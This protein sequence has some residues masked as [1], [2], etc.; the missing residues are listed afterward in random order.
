MVLTQEVLS[1]FSNTLDIEWKQPVH[2]LDFSSCCLLCCFSLPHFLKCCLTET[3]ALKQL[4]MSSF[5]STP[6]IPWA[7][8]SC[9]SSPTAN[10]CYN[11]VPNF[12][13]LHLSKPAWLQLHTLS[14]LVAQ[15]STHPL[16]VL[17]FLQMKGSPCTHWWHHLC[18]T[19]AHIW[20]S[21]S[22]TF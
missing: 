11:M 13:L 3:N 16:C 9:K 8:S 18:E 10:Y 4:L 20:L 1:K 6:L 14:H 5:P 19:H 12:V 22:F 7:H 21:H 15:K 17:T 2:C